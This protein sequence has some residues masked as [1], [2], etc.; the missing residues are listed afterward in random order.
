MLQSSENGWQNVRFSVDPTIRWRGREG[1]VRVDSR[2]SI[3][4][5]RTAAIWRK[6]GV[7]DDRSELLNRASDTCSRTRPVARATIVPGSP[8]RSILC[9][10]TTAWWSGNSIVSADRFRICC[11]SSPACGTETSRSARSPSRWTRL[12]R[13]ANSS[14][15]FSERSP[16]SSGRSPKTGYGLALPPLEGVVGAAA[17]RRRLVRISSRPSDP[18]PG[19]SGKTRLRCPLGGAAA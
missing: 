15:V 12:R 6:P 18:R 3:A 4:V 8:A 10:Q 5:P 16:S 2:G 7:G 9:A 14:S 1:R 19:D 13:M 17:G 11:R